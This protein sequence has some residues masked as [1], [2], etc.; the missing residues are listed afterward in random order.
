MFAVSPTSPPH[1]TVI[2][3]R[4]VCTFGIAL[5]VLAALSC[6]KSEAADTY[7]V[8]LDPAARTEPA[9]G[10]I[11]LFF[12]TETRRPFDRSDPIEGPFFEKP[13]PIASIGVKE[14]KGGDVAT[15]DGSSLAWPASLDTLEGKVRVQAIL[16]ADQITRSHEQGTGNVYSDVVEADLSSKRDDT[17]EITLRHRIDARP[18]RPETDNLKWV[19]LRSEMLSAFYGYDV[20]HRAGVAL[21]Q[22][23]GDPANP[24]T[25]W[26][27]VYW[28]PGFGGRDEEAAEYSEMLLAPGVE[29]IAPIAVYVCLDA[30]APLGHHGFCDSASNGPRGEALVKEFIPYLED[31]FHLVAKPEARIVTGHSSGGWSSLWLQLTH[32]ET[33]GACWS[34]SPDPVDFSCFQM[35]DIY[36]EKNMFAQPDESETPSYRNWTSPSTQSVLMTVRQENGMEHAVDPDGRSGQQWDAWEAMFSPRDDK[37]GLPQPMFDPLTGEIHKAVVENWKRFDMA[38]LIENDWQKYGPIMLQRVRLACGEEDSYYLNRAVAKLKER[39][40]NLQKQH[41]LPAG[42]GYFLLV[43]RADHSTVVPMTYQRWNKEMRDYL[44]HLGL[45]DADAPKPKK[46]AP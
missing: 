32:P 14:L 7:R 13:Q 26:P 6:S 45:Q 4:L 1:E 18:P 31:R 41:P 29:E 35:T 42:D 37:T 5:I 39:I 24:R 19:E 36:S 25:Q 28:I 44:Q 20:F 22:G 9:T 3:R 12:I 27:A 40:D 43:P 2:A 15:L 38:R 46:N 34:R 10:R 16:D 33:F 23:W 8:R 21:P 17:V 11:V 30:D